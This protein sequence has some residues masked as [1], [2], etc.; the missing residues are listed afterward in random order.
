MHRC[1]IPGDAVATSGR[2]DATAGGGAGT[3]C[4]AHDG[5]SG[6]GCR[7]DSTGWTQTSEHD[8]AVGRKEAAA[9]PRRHPAAR[10]RMANGHGTMGAG[11]RPSG[12]TSL[13]RRP[14]RSMPPPH[15]HRTRA[16]ACGWVSIHTSPKPTYAMRRH[17]WPRA[18]PAAAY[19]TRL[20]HDCRVH[21][22]PVP[23][24]YNVIY[25]SIY[26]TKRY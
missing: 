24:H 26:G 19:E 2:A 11:S 17:G 9:Y 4:R 3:T 12:P 8:V 10:N 7:H 18:A 21:S 14:L 16:R 13:F 25:L 6:R 15:P 20:A 5:R 1:T 22:G 23:F